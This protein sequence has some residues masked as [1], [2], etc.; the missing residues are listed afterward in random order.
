MEFAEQDHP[1]N[2]QAKNDTCKLQLSSFM[3]VNSS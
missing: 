2:K 3:P 1:I